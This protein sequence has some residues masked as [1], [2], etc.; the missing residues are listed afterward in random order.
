MSADKKLWHGILKFD[1][2]VVT[3]QPESVRMRTKQI[4]IQL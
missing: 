1:K 3:L 4:N 2:N